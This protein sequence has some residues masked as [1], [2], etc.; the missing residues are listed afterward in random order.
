[1]ELKRIEVRGHDSTQDASCT[2]YLLDDSPEYSHRKRPLILVCPGSG[3]WKPSDRE[4]EAAAMQFCAMG[5]HAA[6]LRYSTAPARFPVAVLEVGRVIKEIREHPEWN[7]LQDKIAVAG[8][9]AGGHLA[10]CYGCMWNQHWLDQELDCRPEQLKPNALLL[11]Y[12]VVTSGLYAHEGSFQNLLG[13]DYEKRKTEVSL[14][15]LVGPQTPTTFMWNTF[16]DQVVPVQNS[17]LMAKALAD[18]D[19]PVEYHLFPHGLHGLAM[20]DDIGRMADGVGE[21]P[22]C[23]CWV[24]LAHRWLEEW[25]RTSSD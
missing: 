15:K 17:I 5:Y 4:G 13:D 19:I 9:S 2:L 8:F 21:E 25:R 16:E 24:Q 10:G 22:S 12:P 18:H 20:A 11:F 7:I 3:Y 6:V 14:E 1:M 23:Q